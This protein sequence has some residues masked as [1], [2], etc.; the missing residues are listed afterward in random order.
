MKESLN[1]VRTEQGIAG[2]A[3]V[4]V[5]EEPPWDVWVLTSSL[6][7]LAGQLKHRGVRGLN[8]ATES[9]IHIVQFG[10][11]NTRVNGISLVSTIHQT[12]VYLQ[13]NAVFPLKPLRHQT[14]AQLVDRLRYL[15]L[16]RH[17]PVLFSQ[18]VSQALIGQLPIRLFREH[19]VSN[20]EH[21]KFVSEAHNREVQ[22]FLLDINME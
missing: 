2:V 14:T 13:T 3:S 8:T 18:G 20:G 21:I 11:F 15:T 12:A 10:L 4:G 7:R 1:A 9:Y 19:S 17:V 16:V 5:A 6:A 22:S